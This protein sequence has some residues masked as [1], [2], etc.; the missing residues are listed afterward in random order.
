[1]IKPKQIINIFFIVIILSFIVV[2]ANIQY[3]F[4]KFNS[5]ETVTTIPVNLIN[6]VSEV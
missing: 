4:S 2:Y 5:I 6:K 1:M 3:T